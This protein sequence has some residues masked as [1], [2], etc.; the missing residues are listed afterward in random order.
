MVVLLENV[1]GLTVTQIEKSL[2]ENIVPSILFGAL[3]V[4]FSVFVRHNVARYLRIYSPV[5][6]SSDAGIISLITTRSFRKG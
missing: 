5:Q 1:D 6:L 3:S 4:I 2:L